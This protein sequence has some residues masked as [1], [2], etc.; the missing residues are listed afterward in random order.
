MQESGSPSAVVRVV[1]EVV[2]PE[3]A[4]KRPCGQHSGTFNL[5]LEARTRS[6]DENG[7]YIN[8]DASLAPL[9]LCW[10]SGL[11]HG[12][13]HLHPVILRRH[14][15]LTLRK[16]LP[17]ARASH[18]FSAFRFHGVLPSCCGHAISIPQP[19][20]IPERP[21]RSG[22]AAERSA[23]VFL[24]VGSGA[25]PACTLAPSTAARRSAATPR[26]CA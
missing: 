17:P 16:P 24:V 2:T 3:H 7:P 8:R 23:T 25:T 21:S 9:S 14:N 13:Y 15:P 6:R 20:I 10:V 26:S 19:G 4:A 1:F 22:R 5:P 18:P 11:P 12:A